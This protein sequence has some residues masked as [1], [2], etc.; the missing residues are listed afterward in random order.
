MEEEEEDKKRRGRRKE[1][2][3]RKRCT[4]KGEVSALIL[5]MSV[6]NMSK[7]TISAAMADVTFVR[8]A[9]I[10]LTTCRRTFPRGGSNTPTVVLM[11]DI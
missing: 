11:R 4:T 6:L 8:S 3:K 9:E 2:L 10:S 5:T 7:T 1:I